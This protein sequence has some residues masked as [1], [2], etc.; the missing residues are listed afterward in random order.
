MRY[1]AGEVAADPQAGD[2]SPGSGCRSVTQAH[3][4][5]VE[6]IVLSKHRTSAATSVPV[7]LPSQLSE[8]S[9]TVGRQVGNRRKRELVKRESNQQT[10]LVV[11]NVETSILLVNR[12][13]N[14]ERKVGRP[15]A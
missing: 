11:C 3:A 13:V 12:C 10:H 7:K 9:G 8:L 2:P 5:G 14:R 6:D 15:G 1:T 4:A